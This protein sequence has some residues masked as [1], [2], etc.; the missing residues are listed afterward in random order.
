VHYLALCNKFAWFLS[1]CVR[2]DIAARLRTSNADLRCE[3][4]R[5]RGRD[6]CLRHKAKNKSHLTINCSKVSTHLFRRCS[7][8]HYYIPYSH[9]QIVKGEKKGKEEEQ[10]KQSKRGIKNAIFLVCST[11]SRGKKEREDHPILSLH[12]IVNDRDGTLVCAQRG[13]LIKYFSSSFFLTLSI[14]VSLSFFYV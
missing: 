11:I 14:D 7:C 8:H 10:K 5:E 6:N 1:A 9:I 2:T 13:I 3:T 12:R 4:K